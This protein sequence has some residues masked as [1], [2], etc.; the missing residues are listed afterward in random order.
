MKFEQAYLQMLK[1]KKVKR[2]CFKETWK[3]DGASGKLLI[4]SS[5]NK[6]VTGFDT[7]LLVKNTLAED[8]EIVK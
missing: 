6:E 8:W 3:I 5:E 1:G 7:D 4:L 2:P